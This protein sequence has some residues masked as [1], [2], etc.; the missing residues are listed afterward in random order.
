[1]SLKDN[2]NGLVIH[3]L[4]NAMVSLENP[5]VI[6]HIECNIN[7]RGEG[8]QFN[9]YDIA[10][11]V[12]SNYHLNRNNMRL[13]QL[14]EIEDVPVKGVPN[15]IDAENHVPGSRN[16]ISDLVNE[17]AT[18][19]RAV[20]EAGSKQLQSP[21][22][23]S[24]GSQ[25]PQKNVVDKGKNIMN[26]G[27][28]ST[29]H[30]ISDNYKGGEMDRE[31]K[32][33]NPASKNRGSI[34][35][36]TQEQQEVLETQIPGQMDVVQSE[37]ASSSMQELQNEGTIV[38]SIDSD[39]EKQ[40][41]DQPT[42]HTTLQT[43]DKRE[44]E[45]KDD[46]P[47]SPSLL[48]QSSLD[49][50]YSKLE[51]NNGQSGGKCARTPS[52]SNDDSLS[53]EKI[54]EEPAAVTAN[55]ESGNSQPANEGRPAVFP[56]PDGSPPSNGDEY[57]E[58][59]EASDDLDDWSKA[60]DVTDEEDI[61]NYDLSWLFSEEDDDNR[62][63]DLH[64]TPEPTPAP[65]LTPE[66][67]LSLTSKKPEQVNNTT[68]QNTKSSNL[69]IIAASILAIAGVALGVTIAVHLEM[70]AVGIVVG[71]CCLAATAVMYHYKWPSSFIE[72]NK[73]EKVAPNEKKEPVATSV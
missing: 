59:S 63:E 54:D 25:Q 38:S 34:P 12:N 33:Q 64:P 6:S 47:D 7:G 71:A 14:C 62:Q 29:K 72:N 60:S 11:F 10:S 27:H 51:S 58:L 61:D 13:R 20:N 18:S 17:P 57:D 4:G 22:P 67:T 53:F 49:S 36:H 16:T 56:F 32:Q 23:K 30:P 65:T 28:A 69:H 70:L 41:P 48:P 73:V 31:K 52:D 45:S 26:N 15:L 66:P 40:S 68:P 3:A 1:M 44:S 19:S 42:E 37:G 43:D 2:K 8:L 24:T 55:I 9:I 35:P 46:Q 50:D 39:E 5:L 21:E